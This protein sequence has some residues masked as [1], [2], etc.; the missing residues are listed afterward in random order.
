MGVAHPLASA[1]RQIRDVLPDY[2]F[3]HRLGAEELTAF[4]AGIDEIVRTFE[5][6]SAAST[7]PG[8]HAA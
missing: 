1:I 7:P 2:S 6:A 3:G 4:A 8:P 5:L